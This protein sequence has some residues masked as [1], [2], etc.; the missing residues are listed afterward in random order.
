MHDN[1][2]SNGG[3]SFRLIV[4]NAIMTLK[5][6]FDFSVEH[7]LNF[8][9]IAPRMNDILCVGCYENSGKLFYSMK[10]KIFFTDDRYLLIGLFIET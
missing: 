1:D 9:H 3:S 5:K 2:A 8:I 7:V 10:N 4:N 6:V